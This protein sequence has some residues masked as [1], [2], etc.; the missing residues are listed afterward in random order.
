[1]TYFFGRTDHWTLPE[2]AMWAD[3]AQGEMEVG[4]EKKNE[5]MASACYIG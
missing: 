3:E 2:E 5:Q 1:M 4:E